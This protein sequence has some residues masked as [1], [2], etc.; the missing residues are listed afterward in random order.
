[1]VV[2][3]YGERLYRGLV[4]TETAHLHKVR[5]PPCPAAQPALLRS[6]P[7]PAAQPAGCCFTAGGYVGDGGGT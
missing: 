2:N 7:C 1:M 3:K 4:D 6:L 5:C